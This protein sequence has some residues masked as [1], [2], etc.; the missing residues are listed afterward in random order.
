MK[1]KNISQLTYVIPNVGTFAPGEITPDIVD[2][3][4]PD[5][6]PVTDDIDGG[7]PNQ[8]ENDGDSQ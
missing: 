7:S 8:S 3:L 5:F 4:N 2:L 6:E 1:Y